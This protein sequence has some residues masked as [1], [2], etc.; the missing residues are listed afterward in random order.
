MD[1]NEQ[2]H[3]NPKPLLCSSIS[4]LG[5]V[6]LYFIFSDIL[7]TKTSLL[8]EQYPA[9]KMQVYFGFGLIDIALTI[10]L[11]FF[12]FKMLIISYQKYRIPR[13]FVIIYGIIALISTTI[14]LAIGVQ[15]LI[16]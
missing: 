15:I 3:L 2:Q 11:S 16:I 10:I 5:Y 4:L 13:Y 6:L 12:T 1:N 9:A 8:F 14:N 7:I